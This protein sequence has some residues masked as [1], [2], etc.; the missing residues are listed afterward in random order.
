MKNTTLD[1][2][3]LIQSLTQAEK[4]YCTLYFS[5]F[6][7][8]GDK[9]LFLFKVLSRMNTFEDRVLE[10]KVKAHFSS[11]QQLA[12]GRHY[13][14][15]QMLRALHNF[16]AERDP[17]IRIRERIG[18]AEILLRRGLRTQANKQ[19]E[20]A[21]K[22]AEEY[23][24][25]ESLAEILHLQTV[26][27]I[28]QADLNKLAKY[29]QPQLI[30]EKELNAGLKEGI[31][32]KELIFRFLPKIR[33]AKEV[34][35]ES[36][37]GID[38]WYEQI[39]QQKFYRLKITS[40]TIGGILFQTMGQGDKAHTWRKE[41]FEL[42]LQRP[43][44]ISRW[45]GVFGAAGYQFVMKQITL[46]K[47]KAAAA[48]L[49][50]MKLQYE[51]LG[52]SSDHLNLR[53]LQLRI[54]NLELIF[55]LI[56]LDRLALRE[57]P[58]PPPISL[59]FRGIPGVLEINITGLVCCLLIL[60]N[61]D[62]EALSILNGTIN[63]TPVGYREDIIIVLRTYRALIHLGRENEEFVFYEIQNLIR[64]ARKVE[65][66][67]VWLLPLLRLIQQL[68]V[69]QHPIAQIQTHLESAFTTSEAHIGNWLGDRLNARLLQWLMGKYEE[70][71]S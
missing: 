28:N 66:M 64:K 51:S 39:Q 49:T 22:E 57:V 10:K 27:L 11:R 50:E 35:R 48:A 4:R 45:I 25:L 43:A 16:H 30:A 13:L 68:V 71:K 40:L 52:Q 24:A 70:R 15:H 3:E 7:Q 1:L 47:R 8:K 14:Y 26:D 65:S 6:S 67:K 56:Y 59:S 5:A 60:R 36:V 58:L 12:S 61:Q 54:L 63:Q 23:E 37:E 32:M 2:W 41:L 20:L 42:F 21:K 9:Y 55:Q 33:N 46:G 18:L 62:R 19:L 38:N 53:L 44:M 34:D 69:R 31:Q 29:S 17:M